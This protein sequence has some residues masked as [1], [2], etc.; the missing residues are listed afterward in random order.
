MKRKLKKF[1][2]HSA[3]FGFLLFA[4]SFSLFAQGKNPVIFIPGLAGSELRHKTSNDKIWVKALKSKSEDLRLPIFADPSQALDDLKPTDAI[5]Y[6]KFAGL[7]VFDVYGGFIE[8]MEKRGGYREENWEKPSDKG[9]EDS[10]Y[11]FAYDWRLDNVENAR[12]LMRKVGELKLKL[13]RPELKFDIVAHSMGGLISRY[14]VMY[15]DADLPTDEQKP[16][17]TWAGANHFNKLIL[18]GTPNEGSANS[19]N[20]LVNGYSIGNVRLDL[21]FVQDS[22]KFMVFT[23]PAVYQLLPAPGT[24]RAFDEKLDPVYVDVFDPKT[25]SKYGWN[26]INDREFASRF[27]VSERKLAPAY[28]QAVLDRAKRFHEALAAGDGKTGGVAFY[29]LGSDCK[30]ALDAILIYRDEKADKWKTV[31]RPNGFTRSDGVKIRDDE[32]KKLMLVP[33]DGIVTKRSLEAVK[34]PTA[35]QL[36]CGEHTR[37]AA[38]IRIQNQILE[39]LGGKPLP[40]KEMENNNYGKGR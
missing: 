14:A 22:S 10:L 23:I 9:F 36:I 35:E 27:N 4:L 18:L 11:I 3:K 8:A 15:G 5:R 1:L 38:N 30:T 2:S 26:V 17:P 28:F 31:F 7:S 39:I 25:W 19:L 16:Q 32:L 20:A 6:V 13:K 21:P 24:L 34:V 33:G 29:V 40:A 12:L 37:L